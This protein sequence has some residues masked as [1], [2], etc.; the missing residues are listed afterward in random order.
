VIVPKTEEVQRWYGVA[1]LLVCASDIESLPL[2]VLEAMAW[3]LPVLAT[4]VFGLPELIEDGRNGW[5]CEPN[6]VAALAAGLDTALSDDVET[7]RRIGAAGREAL[8]G[9][10]RLDS[11]A[12]Q[13]AEIF[14]LAAAG[15]D[16]SRA[17]SGPAPERRSAPDSRRG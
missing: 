11:Y 10:H 12:R 7:R 4:R 16:V 2:T 15:E 17:V 13:V 6:D 5:L 1:D 8:A 9:R 3:E 14:D